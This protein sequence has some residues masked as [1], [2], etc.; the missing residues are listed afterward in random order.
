[1]FGDISFD[2]ADDA[3]V[4]SMVSR[5]SALP[6]V[7]RGRE[8]GLAIA[9]SAEAAASPSV[10]VMTTGEK[11]IPKPGQSPLVIDLSA[12]WAGPLAAHLLWLAGAEV[13]KVES[14]SRPDA[15]RQGDPALFALLNQGKASAVAD[16]GD[17]AGRKALSRLI[18][19]A[20]I[21]IE[22]ARPRALRQLGID[23]RS[24]VQS[25][26]GL[27][28]ITITGHGAEGEAANWTG[29]GDD[30][31]VAGG[32]SAALEQA[33]GST[34]AA[35]AWR[36]W[37]SGSACRI[38]LSM[39]GIAAQALS[40]ERRDNPAALNDDL[41]RWAASQGQPFPARP[42]RTVSSEVRHLGADTAEWLGPC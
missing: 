6:L 22:A 16:L 34:A 15:M 17:E 38:G 21:V 8:M 31:G 35:E 37:A 28:W 4:A 36:A 18:A 33:T 7:Q 24:L 39:S 26:P 32:L 12:L 40:E 13:V 10:S 41:R 5:C 29:F 14:R 9:A 23:A 19:R 1:L 27:V 30:C 11:R 25:V 2:P 3:A 20:D 42:S